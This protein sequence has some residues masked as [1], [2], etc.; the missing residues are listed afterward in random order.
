MDEFRE[1]LRNRIQERIKARGHCVLYNND[2]SRFT[3]PLPEFRQQQIR[4]IQTFA[5]KNRLAV[6]IR[7]TG[8]NATF[9]SVMPARP[10]A[11]AKKE[12]KVT[13]TR[14]QPLSKFS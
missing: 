7:D 5:A 10:E 1:K 6:T 11:A 4:D 8:L 13:K 12:T 14:P 3:P 9:T 2:L